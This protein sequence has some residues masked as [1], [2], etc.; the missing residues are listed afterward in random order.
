[1]TGACPDMVAPVRA[2][3]PEGAL[4]EKPFKVPALLQMMQEARGW[5]EYLKGTFP[6]NER[7]PW[8]AG[9]SPPLPASL[10]EDIRVEVAAG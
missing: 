7:K 9:T 6:S 3:F 5:Q 8:F 10:T 4:L 2:H 1:M